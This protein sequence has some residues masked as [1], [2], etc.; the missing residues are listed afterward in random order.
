MIRSLRGNLTTKEVNRVV[1]DARGVGFEVH[2]PLSTSCGLGDPGA[3]VA[4]HVHMHVREGA[5]ALFGFATVHELQLFERL[6]A[7][8]GVGPRV[9]LAVLSGIE[10]PDLVRAI[11][12]GDIAR[13]TRIPGV[14]RKTAERIGHELRESLPPDVDT[15]S[16]NG[17][18]RGAGDTLRRDVLSALMNLGYHRALAER[19]V[20]AAVGQG[21]GDEGL[22][23]TLRRALRELAK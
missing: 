12:D 7:V 8:G 15:E 9:A 10:L 6:I 18:N 19:A 22:E 4:L 13:L 1:I 16:E 3:E 21:G 2:V 17:D 5:L 20:L 11:R 14:G 23:A